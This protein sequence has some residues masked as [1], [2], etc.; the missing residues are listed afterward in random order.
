MIDETHQMLKALAQEPE[1]RNLDAKACSGFFNEKLLKHAFPMFTNLGLLDPK[2]KLVCSAFSGLKTASFSDQPY[3]KEVLETKGFSVGLLVTGAQQGKG[4]LSMGYPVLDDSGSLRGIVFAYLELGWLNHLASHAGLP[5][6]AT[7]TAIDK[8]GNVVARSADAEKWVGRSAPDSEIIKKVLA[9]GRGQT[10]A[11][12]IDGVQKI[13]GFKQVGDSFGSLYVYVGVPRN[14]VVASANRLLFFDLVWLAIAILVA[15][16]AVWVFT[17]YLITQQL[18]RLVTAANKIADGNLTVRTGMDRNQGE[19]G[20]LGSAFDQMAKAVQ[21][22]ELESERSHEALQKE[23]QFSEMV[24]DSLPGIFYLFDATGKMIRWNHNTETITGYSAE[25]ISK[26]SP[27]D[28]VL[29]QERSLLVERIKDALETGEA[30]M[31]AHYVTKSG[32]TIPYYFTGKMAGID[33][34]KSVIGVGIDIS[35]RKKVEKALEDSERL[36]KTI[37]AASPVGI[38]V[39]DKREIK[40]ANDAW[41]NM[42]GY[43]EEKDYVGQSASILYQSDEEFQRVGQALYPGLKSVNVSETEAKMKRHDGTLF[44]AIIRIA[45]LNSADPDKESIVAVVSDISERKHQE[46]KLSESEERYRNLVETMTE[47]LGLVDERGVINYVNARAAE[48]LGYSRDEVIDHRVDEF[49]SE[50]SKQVLREQMSR[51]GS[52]PSRSYE[53][54]WIAKD[55]QSVCTL[56]SS[57]TILGSNGKNLGSLAT[58]TDITARRKYRATTT[59][60][61]EED[62]DVNRASPDR[63]RYISKWEIRLCEPCPCDH[64]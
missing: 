15:M 39:A 41:I 23:K 5:T 4:A 61:R 56:I 7:L 42:F 43:K 12:G 22:R 17:H 28:L 10:E 35:A 20:F 8:M 52:E 57:R 32:D 30:S 54:D 9:D 16:C 38:H 53:L 11:T 40:W 26:S 58:V 51:R 18:D 48:M 63:R 36:L 45:R 46:R 6:H 24:I 55:G 3:L 60:F 50:S 62:A 34:N 25:E 33:Q 2:G 59:G 19:I 44:D 37:L 13:Y 21:D 29:E 14:G 31:E 64:T 27:L 47:G 49:L 1:I